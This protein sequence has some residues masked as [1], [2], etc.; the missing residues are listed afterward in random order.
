MNILFR[1]RLRALATFTLWGGVIGAFLGLL[2][3]WADR[4]D[5]ILAACRGIVVGFLIGFG[6]GTGEELLFPRWSRNVGFKTLNVTRVLGYTLLIGVALILVNA[7]DRSMASGAGLLESVGAYVLEG[8][9]RRDLLFA[10]AAAILTTSFLEVR[11]LHNPGEIWR[12]LSGR[13]HY[14]EEE[15]RVFLF[16][17]LVNSTHIAETLGHL[18]FS[19]FLRSCFS[20]VSEAILAWRGQVYQHAGDAVIVSWPLAEGLKNAACLRCFFDMVEALEAKR[21]RYLA[22]FGREPRLRAGIHGGAVMTTWVGEARKD[23]AFHGDTVNLTARLEGL[24]KA[25]EV[26]CLASAVVCGATT[27]PPHLE[28]RSVGDV[29]LKGR[30][31]PMP[32]FEVRRR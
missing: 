22:E 17:D 23:L 10:V 12:L 8:G 6:V 26:Q 25:L 27:L 19:A 30:A 28:A 29:E 21:E 18:A 31:A 32:V 3:G 7:G 13:Y 20:D 16:A 9:M 15:S 1:K 5:L 11:K 4:V 2:I 24:C 14:P